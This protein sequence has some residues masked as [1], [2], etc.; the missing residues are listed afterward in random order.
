MTGVKVGEVHTRWAAGQAEVLATGQG[1][2]ERLVLVELLTVEPGQGD[3]PGGQ[4]CSGV[5]SEPSGRVKQQVKVHV[6][7]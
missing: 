2:D 6:W 7:Q 5:H 3:L 1:L 4:A